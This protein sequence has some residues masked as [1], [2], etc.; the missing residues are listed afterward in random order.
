MRY[1]K[2]ITTIGILSVLW[3]C[4]QEDQ[5]SA[6][7]ISDIAVEVPLRRF[8]KAL[9]SADTTRLPQELEKIQAEYPE[10]SNIFFGQILGA[11]DPAVQ[12]TMSPAEYIKGFVTFPAVREL[13]DTCMHLYDDFSAEKASFEKAF[14][15]LKFYFPDLPTPDLTTF[16]SEYSVGVFIYKDNSLAVGLDFFLGSDYP[17]ARLNPNNPAFSAYL[18]RTFNRDHLVSKTIRVLV[19]DMTGAPQGGKM[20]DVMIHRGKQMYLLDQM[21]PHVADTAVF[22]FSS[23]QLSWLQD[24]EMDI[25]AFFLSED[26]LYS[27]DMQKYRKYVDY[28][29]NAPGMP[30]EAPGRTANW[31]GYQIVKSYM[32]NVRSAT[33]KDLV[34]LKD[35]QM[36]MDKSRYKPKRR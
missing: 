36:I 13:Y 10:F 31:M 2:I 28:S 12:N 29:P 3:G 26:L 20:L 21:L 5:P 15:Y 8:E 17:Y 33:L 4:Q 18:T 24:N 30:I 11:N 6:P 34:D 22:E 35:A 14:Q 23:P 32:R 25:W 27:T 19:E 7:N 1:T 9:F 16:I